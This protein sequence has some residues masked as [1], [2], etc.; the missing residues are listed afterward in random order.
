MWLVSECYKACYQYQLSKVLLHM[1]M[2]ELSMAVVLSQGWDIYSSLNASD[3][4]TCTE[5]LHPSVRL[6]GRHSSAGT[7]FLYRTQ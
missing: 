7:A 2:S 3:V 4:V 1:A 5:H 6:Q